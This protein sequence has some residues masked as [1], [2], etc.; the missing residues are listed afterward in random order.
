[1]S[2]RETENDGSVLLSVMT[3][4]Y[5]NNCYGKE[6]TKADRDAYHITFY[7][8]NSVCQT[9]YCNPLYRHFGYSALSV[10]VSTV[11]LLR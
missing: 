6:K 5:S 1:M 11:D 2:E 9:L 3:L 10:I 8:K 7:S 4:F